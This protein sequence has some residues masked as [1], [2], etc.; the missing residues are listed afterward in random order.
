MASIIKVD[1]IQ[2][3]TANVFFQNSAG[4]EYARFD[5]SGN[6][7]IGTT[8]PSNYQ[9]LVAITKS[10]SASES[11]PLTLVNP[12]ATTSTAVSLG[13]SPNVNIDLA[14]ITAFR[15]DSGGAGATDLLFKTY[16]GS[17]LTEKVRID[18]SG[19]VG[20][21]TS[22]ASA[23][24]EV[25][26]ASAVSAVVIKPQGSILNN[27]DNAGLQ[28]QHQ[29]T[30]GTAFRVRADTALTASYFTHILLNNASA[31]ATALQVDQ[32]GTGNIVDFTKSGTVALRI[33]NAG[34]VAIGGTTITAAARLNVYQADSSQR[35][36]HFENT[37][38]VSTD[39]NLR[40][41][42]GSN[43]NNTASYLLIASTGGAD[44][45]YLYGN[46]TYATVS[47]QRLKK[48]IETARDGYLDDVMKLRVVKYNWIGDVENT[49]KELGWIAQEVEEVFPGLVQD[50]LPN[51]DGDVYKTVKS[52]V[53]PQI[54]LKAIQEQQALITQLQADV[55]AL[56][57]K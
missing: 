52:S 7:G 41:V 49:P 48:N 33:D 9:G 46:G 47:D 12:N 25:I 53:L 45:F 18:S 26:G 20:I 16:S 37:R 50:T 35:V 42:L 23:K 39:E 24:L 56:K 15:T 29:G 36:V 11:V 10:V 13:F 57:A 31:A 5:S 27:N 1:T 51:K 34:D 54:L 30:G 17:S 19:N 4:T 3:T 38:N 14:R 55:A 43:C 21:G 28:I 2:S 6:M 40:I 8:S 22:S 32:Y 44:K